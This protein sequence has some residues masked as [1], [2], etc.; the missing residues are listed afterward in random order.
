LV[1][2]GELYQ[3]IEPQSEEVAQA[4]ALA[5]TPDVGLGV[6]L[7]A[8]GGADGEALEVRE[9]NGSHRSTKLTFT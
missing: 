2:C 9:L 4:R 5:L 1:D 3:L 7:L 8:S 6:Q